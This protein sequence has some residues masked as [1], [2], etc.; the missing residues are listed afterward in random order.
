MLEEAAE[1]KELRSTCDIASCSSSCSGAE[2]PASSSSSLSLR[3][4]L[5]SNL[6]SLIA[7]LSSFEPEFSE[8]LVWH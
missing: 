7:F 5:F 8:L 4:R 2:A 3:L 6:I 1:D